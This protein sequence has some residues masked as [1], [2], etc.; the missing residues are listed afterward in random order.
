MTYELRDGQGSLFKNSKREK[1]THPNATGTAMIGGKVYYVSA[2]TKTTKGGDKFQ[3]LAFK[4]KNER[5][6]HPAAPSAPLKS[7]TC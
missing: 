5:S 7:Q 2:W 4:E 1:E 3:S 6:T